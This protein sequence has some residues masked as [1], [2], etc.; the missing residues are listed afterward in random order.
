MHKQW[1]QRTN[2]NYTYRKGNVFYFRRKIPSD[3]RCH[4]NRPVFVQ[5]LRTTSPQS[6]ERAA[7][8]LSARLDEQW[9]ILRLKHNLTPA[10]NLLVKAK[11]TSE[12]PL[13][14]ELLETYLKTKG[15]GKA[16]LFFVNARRNVGYVVSAIGDQSID[17]YSKTDAVNFRDWLINKG[18]QSS[19]IHRVFSSVRAIINFSINEYGYSFSNPFAGVY[20]AND[21]EKVK[22]RSLTSGELQLLSLSCRAEDDEL[23]HLFGLL[24]NTGMRLGEATGL[25]TSE[26][27][28]DV[29]YPYLQVKPNSAR[30]LKTNNSKRIVP[31]AGISLWAAKRVK[32]QNSGY[33]FPHY[34]TDGKCNANSASAALGKWLKNQC[35]SGAT[36][37][38]IRH[39]FRDRLRAIEA[40]VDLID[41]LGGWSSK[42]IGF[43]YGDGYPVST[44]HKYVN[45][46][47]NELEKECITS[48]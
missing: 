22:R 38:G 15:R 31:L 30:R 24:V 46:M 33:C 26:L 43:G 5:S 13:L 18:L 11:V 42:S 23:R 28:L 41:Q 16:D 44:A 37:H 3:L 47:S 48:S 14:S 36:I 17:L 1:H 35:E 4:Y 40:P 32:E 2:P 20:I 10:S 21:E 9:L 25:H 29:D 27:F 34:T 45:R 7:A 19:S 6:A 8:V 12:L 39:A